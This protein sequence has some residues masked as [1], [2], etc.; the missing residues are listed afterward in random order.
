MELRFVVSDPPELYRMTMILLDVMPELMVSTLPALTYALVR[1]RK[2]YK[3]A[4][5]IKDCAI[6]LAI[7]AS[8]ERFSKKRDNIVK[9]AMDYVLSREMRSLENQK[10]VAPPKAVEDEL[11]QFIVGG[12]D[13]VRRL[14]KE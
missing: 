3:T 12:F 2:T 1:R 9:C 7:R 4:L 13:S 8:R 5:S 14:L 11:F 6:Q 10:Q